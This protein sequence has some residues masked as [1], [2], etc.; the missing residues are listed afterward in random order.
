MFSTL[1]SIAHIVS[2]GLQKRIPLLR[3][4]NR[5]NTIAVCAPSLKCHSCRMADRDDTCWFAAA[6]QIVKITGKLRDSSS[7]PATIA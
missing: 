3:A 4:A 1:S 5:G 6:N 2:R 7:C